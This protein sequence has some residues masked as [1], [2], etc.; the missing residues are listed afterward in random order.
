MG[1]VEGEKKSLFTLKITSN[2]RPWMK[3]NWLILFLLQGGFFFPP[4]CLSFFVPIYSQDTRDFG[5]RSFHVCDQHPDAATES[6]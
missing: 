6:V 4:N 5:Q 3:I 2:L 1:V